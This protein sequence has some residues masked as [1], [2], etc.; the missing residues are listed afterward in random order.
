MRGKRTVLMAV[1]MMALACRAASAT[2]ILIPEE[3]K[4]PPLAVRSHRVHAQVRDGVAATRVEEVFHNST[5]RQLEATFVFPLPKEAALTDFAMYVNGK[6]QGGEVVEAGKARR[7]YE[8][9]VRRLRDPGLLEY[10]DSGLLRMRVFP[11]QPRSDVKV[12]VSYSHAL[13]YDAGVYQYRFPMRTGGK[14]SKVLED[15]TL[16]VEIASRRAIKS[17]YCPTHKVGVTRKDDHHAVAGFEKEGARL[18]DDF[19]LYYT[20][21]K[22]DFGLNLL[23]HRAEG[24][25]GYFALMLAPR[26]ELPEQ[27]VMAKDVCFVIDVSGSMNDGNRIASARDAL[28]FC[29]RALNPEDRFAIIT[30]SNT[31]DTHG[32]DLQKATPAA[33]R[34]AVEYVEGL[35]ADGGTDLCGGVTKA[36]GM[37][38]DQKRPYMVV[39]ATDGK[40]T[41]NVTEPD[42][43]I[44]RVKEANG[45]AARVFTFG[46]AE[47]LDVPLLDGIAEATGGYSEYVAPGRDIE[48]KISSFFR[49]VSHPVLANLELDFGDVGVRDVYPP[50]LPDLFRGSQVVAFGRYSGAGDVAVRLTGNVG[51]ERHEFIYDASFPRASAENGFVRNL[52][53]RRKIGFLLDQIRLHGESEE[54]KDEVIRLSED[55]GIATPYTSYLVLEDEEAYRR[56]GVVRAE[57][58]EELRGQGLPLDSPAAYGAANGRLRADA[59]MREKSMLSAPR[60]AAAGEAIAFSRKLGDWKGAETVQER[61]AGV[62]RVEGK[63]FVRFGGAFVDSEYRKGMDTLRVKWGSDAYFRLLDALPELRPYLA[64]GEHVVVVIEGKALLVSDQGQEEMAVGKIRAF[65]GK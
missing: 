28:E 42:E 38:P 60:Q 32:A 51:G 14:A 63:T 62:Q 44:A 46:I 7:I 59:L 58:L 18:D 33:V 61:A 25:D 13:S 29:L 2:G 6:R 8:D 17:V 41:V 57:A 48:V 50:R 9:I 54:L 20:V 21:S 19:E 55:Y 31:V 3:Q 26:V 5:D 23:A 4:L 15:F 36:L 35:K 56:H 30:F 12:E 45:R 43:I 49:K 39:L 1:V 40:P 27:K 24:E 52:W 47:N 11:I 22:K 16:T 53:A 10:M 65:F 64:L 34:E 37:A